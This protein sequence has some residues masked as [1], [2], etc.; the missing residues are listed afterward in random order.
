MKIFKMGNQ[1]KYR[2]FDVYKK[3]IIDKVR[4]HNFDKYSLEVKSTSIKI[5]FTHFRHNFSE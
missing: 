2:N 1:S 5:I 3:E 4:A